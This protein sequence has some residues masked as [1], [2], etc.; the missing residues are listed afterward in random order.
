MRAVDAALKNISLK[1]YAEDHEELREALKKW[2]A[3]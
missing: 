3:R 2:G 1:K